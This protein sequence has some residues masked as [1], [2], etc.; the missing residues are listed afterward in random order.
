[1]IIKCSDQTCEMA[2][3]IHFIYGAVCSLAF[4]TLVLYRGGEPITASPARSGGQCRAM[5]EISKPPGETWNKGEEGRIARGL[6]ILA[7]PS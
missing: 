5:F 7:Q 2:A 1:M 4:V 6:L 3:R